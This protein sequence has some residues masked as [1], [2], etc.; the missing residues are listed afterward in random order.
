[1]LPPFVAYFV[2]VA[3][4]SLFFAFAYWAFDLLYFVFFCIIFTFIKKIEFKELEFGM[5][6]NNVSMEPLAFPI[7]EIFQSNEDDEENKLIIEFFK[8]VKRE[9]ENMPDIVCSTKQIIKTKEKEGKYHDLCLIIDEYNTKDI[10]SER[11]NTIYNKQWQNNV[12]AYL[13]NLRNYIHK[14]YNRKVINEEMSKNCNCSVFL[15]LKNTEHLVKTF[16]TKPICLH[17]YLFGINYKQ[18]VFYIDVVTQ[19]IT[20]CHENVDDTKPSENSESPNLFFLFLWMI[21]FLILLDSLQALDADVASNLQVIKRFCLK[22]IEESTNDCNISDYSICDNL[23]YFHC[24]S[25]KDNW[26]LLPSSC[27]IPLFYVIYLLITRIFNQK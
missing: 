15:S 26:K 5:H 8:N 6:N 16:Q 7:D 27:P 9:K 19:Y 11:E 10:L 1:M 24:K 4:R 3:S 14:I 22:Q 25:N 13:T 17:L 23:I 12:C 2:I 21:Y 18:V 20:T